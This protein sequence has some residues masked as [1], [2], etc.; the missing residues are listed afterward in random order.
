MRAVSGLFRPC[1]GVVFRDIFRFIKNR[2]ELMQVVCGQCF[3]GGG[4]G[5]SVKMGRKQFVSCLQKTCYGALNQCM[6]MRCVLR[7]KVFFDEDLRTHVVHRGVCCRGGSDVCRKVM[8]YKDLWRVLPRGWAR[9]R[10]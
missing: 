8:M 7:H 3:V 4:A 2:Q 5:N 9:S 10:V 6:W 1:F